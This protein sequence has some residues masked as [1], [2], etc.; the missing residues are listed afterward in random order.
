MKIGGIIGGIFRNGFELMAWATG[1]LSD[2]AIRTAKPAKGLRKLSD[3]KGLQF[4]ITPQGGR[5]WRYEYRFAGKRKLVALGTYPEVSISKAR[6][7]AKLAR[8]LVAAG[9]DP[10]EAKRQA[11]IDSRLLTE[12]IFANIAAKLVA[13]KLKS[14]RAAVTISKMEWILGKVNSEL[15]LKPVTSITVQDIVRCLTKQEQSENFET[16]KRMRTVIGEVF[17]YAMQNGLVDRDPT[18]ATKGLLTK[19]KP[20]HFSA[21]LKPERFGDLLRAIDDY[22]T[23][24]LLTGSA[25]QLMALLYP[26]PGELRQA[27]WSEF[28]LEN[29]IWEIPAER[30]KLRTAHVKILPKQA[31]ATLSALH[32]VTGPQGFVFPAIGRSINSMSENTLNDA[33]RRMGFAAHE[34]SSHGFRATAS[35]LLNAAN[36]FSSDAIERSLA[37]Q[38]KDAVRRAYARGDAMTERKR[39]AQWWADYLDRLR[40]DE[41]HSE[42]IIQLK[43]SYSK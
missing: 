42:N 20:K 23:R 24:N 7:K 3:G 41:K 5:Y 26:R 12:T 33:L 1:K 21:I 4:W 36:I 8:E 9:S 34:Q 2:V 35:T 11:K 30:M 27:K 40:A 31:V 16:A 32:G 6:D 25:L 18:A 13:K 43:T 14:G 17:R 22:A 28:D 19:H 15:G 38:D 37:H 39:M 29:G 10:S